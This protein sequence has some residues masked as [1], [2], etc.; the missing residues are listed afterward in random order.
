MQH[1]ELF[2]VF[3]ALYHFVVYTSER[4]EEFYYKK[5]ILLW[6]HRG[7][8][9]GGRAYN[10]YWKLI[11][12]Q[13]FPLSPFR[14]NTTNKITLF[15]TSTCKA[16]WL[17]VYY[18]QC[19]VSCRKRTEI[20]IEMYSDAIT[21]DVIVRLWNNANIQISTQTLANFLIANS[22][23][24]ENSPEFLFVAPADFDV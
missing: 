17:D 19:S 4:E 16:R 5:C 6:G 10:K 7:M 23:N 8:V 18:V 24:V 9:S 14:T 20:C 22:C 3:V 13:A 15:T 1:D 21:C 12:Q 11:H 2:V